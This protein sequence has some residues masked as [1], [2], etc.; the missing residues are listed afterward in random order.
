[1]GTIFQVETWKMN[2]MPRDLISA[3]RGMRRPAGA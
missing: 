2:K 3:W 1:L